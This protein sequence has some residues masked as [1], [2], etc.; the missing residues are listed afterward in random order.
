MGSTKFQETQSILGGTCL[1]D[2]GHLGSSL[3]R[4]W[5]YVAG[6]A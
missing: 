3:G 1:L 5:L 4:S 6:V 2:F